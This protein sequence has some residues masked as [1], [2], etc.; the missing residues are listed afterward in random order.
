MINYFIKDILHKWRIHKN[1]DRIGPDMPF[2]HWKLHLSTMMRKLCE[3]KF[4][5][6]APTSDFRPGAYAIACSKISLGANVVIRPATMLFAD[7]YAGIEIED[8]VMI[9]AGAHFYVNNHKFDERKIPIIEQGY[10]P[11]EPIRVKEGA[12]IGANSI[13]LPGV[14]IGKNSVIGAGSV[15][16]KSI[17][18]YCIAVGTP[19]RII[20]KIEHE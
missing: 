7:D 1:A 15:V 14:V 20:K 3:E 6:F 17:P 5:S 10:Y 16:T 12:W 4:L 8:N 13:I 9:G 19:A 18:D 2:S 11:S